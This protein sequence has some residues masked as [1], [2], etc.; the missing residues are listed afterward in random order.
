VTKHS[1]ILPVLDSM[2]KFFR[3]TRNALR[4]IEL[5]QTSLDQIKSNKSMIILVEYV[6]R[7][8]QDTK[9]SKN[10][11]N[12]IF[13]NS[14]AF[15]LKQAAV[16][17]N[18]QSR[19]GKSKENS[20]K[21]NSF[22]HSKGNIKESKSTPTS[23]KHKKE[24]MWPVAAPLATPTNG[25][26]QDAMDESENQT[27]KRKSVQEM[28]SLS[29]ENQILEMTEAISA[30]QGQMDAVSFSCG[31]SNNHTTVERGLI[32][33]DKR[34]SNLE[35]AMLDQYELPLS[36]P[37]VTTMKQG[38]EAYAKACQEAKGKH[39]KVGPPSIYLANALCQAMVSHSKQPGVEDF[40][41]AVLKIVCPGDTQTLKY[42][43]Y[44]TFIKMCTLKTA[45]HIAY[46]TIKIEIEFPLIKTFM[47][48]TLLAEGKKTLGGPPPTP[49]LRHL[50]EKLINKGLWGNEKGKG[51]GKG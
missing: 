24:T 19:K 17:R 51:K 41:K 5:D 11:A 40:K 47:Q 50:K 21:K 36:S 38:M 6:K 39:I 12:N 26:A 20:K 34:M 3:K 9:Q 13:L 27:K 43:E 28:Q 49:A 8:Y 15:W 30:L 16:S 2:E 4:N 48:K 33:L 29:P 10:I 35:G 37:L 44:H 25:T 1:Q 32:M 23:L 14:L 7:N 31:D 46:L 18:R 45:K 22:R 42:E